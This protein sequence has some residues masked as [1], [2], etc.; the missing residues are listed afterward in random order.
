MN[1]K[2]TPLP[3]TP[4]KNVFPAAVAKKQMAQKPKGD[5]IKLFSNAFKTKFNFRGVAQKAHDVE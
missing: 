1:E 4:S 3:V 2:E 5:G